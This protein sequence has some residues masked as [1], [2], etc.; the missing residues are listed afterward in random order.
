MWYPFDFPAGYPREPCNVIVRSRLLD[1]MSQ[2]FL[3]KYLSG[4]STKMSGKFMLSHLIEK[5]NAWLAT[6]KAKTQNVTEESYDLDD[7]KTK[8]KPKKKT[9]KKKPSADDEV[10]NEKKASMKTAEEVVARIQWDGGLSTD[11]FII[12]YLDRF[13]GVLEKNFTWFSWEDLASV[14]YDTL[15]IPKHRIQYFKYKDVVVWDKTKRLDNVF[16]STGSGKTIYDVIEQYEREVAAGVRQ[17][18]EAVNE[19]EDN[20]DDDVQVHVG[21]QGQGEGGAVMYRRDEYWGP[22]MRP[23]H[24]LALRITNPDLID[25]IGQMQDQILEMCPEYAPCV[26]PRERMHVTLACLGLDTRKNIDEAAAAVT[27]IGDEMKELN[28]TNITVEFDDVQQFFNTVL[29]AK[30]KEN[31][32]L[33]DFVEHLR[34]SL[35]ESGIEIRDVFEFTPHM[36]ILKLSHQMQKEMACPYL[37]GRLMNMFGGKLLGKQVLGNLHLCEMSAEKRDAEGFYLVEAAVQF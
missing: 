11:C 9:K 33:L 23:T 2:D 7:K 37:D 5:A 13:L 4:E 12:G 3:A 24:F 36:T 29:Y 16:G 15:A 30:V 35:R 27:R 1:P 34:L 25:A 31:K 6:K 32:Q 19:E 10:V 18:A 28:P 22:K 8:Y 17:E 21:A 14:D 26:I 20:D